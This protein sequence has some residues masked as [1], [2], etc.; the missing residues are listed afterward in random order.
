MVTLTVVSP[1]AITQQPQSLTVTNGQLAGF[2]VQV[3][4]TGPLVCQWL[5]NNNN[6]TIYD[7]GIFGQ[8]LQ[9]GYSFSTG[10][11]QQIGNEISVAPGLW[12]LTNFSIKTFLVTDIAGRC[13]E[14]TRDGMLFA[15]F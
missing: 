3:S 10:N 11:G 14:Q 13:P 12:S 2:S 5:F 8:L 6:L 4:G 7:D 9:N 15:V 1:P